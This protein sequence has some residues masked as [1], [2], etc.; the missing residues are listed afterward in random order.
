MRRVRGLPEKKESS[1]F[2]ISR[3]FCIFPLNGNWDTYLEM[4]IAF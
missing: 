1:A 3:I 4:L 2:D